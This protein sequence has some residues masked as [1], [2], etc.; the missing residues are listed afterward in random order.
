MS[1]AT[2]SA[3]RERTKKMLLIVVKNISAL[4]YTVPLLWKIKHENPQADVSVLYCTLSRRKILRKSRFYSDVLSS[5]GIA[6]YDF[7]DFLR[8]PYGK[9][10]GLWRRILSKSDRDSP[11][12]QRFQHAPLRK[13]IRFME[14]VPKRIERF[15]IGKVKVQ[16][17]LPSLDPDIIF[18]DNRAVTA[19]HGRDHFYDYFARTKKKVVLLPHAA[20]HT[21]T[22]AFTPFDER[23]ERLPDYCEFWMPFRFD[24]SWENLPEKKSQFAYVGYPG[25]DSEW[26]AW[27]QS[28]AKRPKAGSWHRPDS[29]EP[30]Q[31]LFVIRK[32]LKE[33]RSRPL[34]HDPYIF[35]HDEFTYYLN[36]V[37]DALREA[38]VDI[39][40]V[41][42]P[43]PS[44]DFWSVSEALQAS[45]I[46]RWRITDDSVY[47]QVPHCDFVVS[48]YST[49]M[50]IPAIAGI[51]VLLL[52][53]R[54]QDEIHQWHEMK[55]LYTGLHFYLE[56]PEDLPVRLKEVI[57]IVLEKR[58][59][60]GTTW[61]GDIEHLRYFYPEGAMQRCLDRLGV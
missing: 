43:H 10:H 11:L 38:G 30:L 44:N 52:H 57:E 26:L 1:G 4:D 22:T 23:G 47:A 27:L 9:L 56:N 58:Q 35:D 32:F 46:P 7:A 49:T 24:R 48:L 61:K 3:E 13:V 16:Q 51:P 29:T 15:L 18:F 12:W 55:Q 53:S 37:G 42:K 45:R 19:F 21:G 60:S 2:Q 50:L 8:S 41:V 25:L 54:I 6:E 40:L 5:C 34:G 59:T 31:C 39:E 33:G 28:A 17:I 36:L 20:H 14:R